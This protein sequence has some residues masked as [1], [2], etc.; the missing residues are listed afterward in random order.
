[1]TV[2]QV[3]K[4]PQYLIVGAGIVGCSLAY[5]FSKHSLDVTVIEAG[6]LGKQGASAVPMALLNPN[7]GR[8]ARAS[9]LD[10]NGLAAMQ[11]LA[12]E[13]EIEGLEHGLQFPGVLRIA[14]NEK[15]RKKFAKLDGVQ[16]L[17]AI[18]EPYHA[19]FGG[20]LVE[21]GGWLEPQKF[22][23]ALRFGAKQRGVKFIEHTRVEGRWKKEDGRI[24]V[25]TSAD[26][27]CA[28]KVFLCVGAT[29]NAGFD[30]PELERIE[31]DVIALNADL[32]MPYPI[33][34]A[35]YGM[36][37]G[38]QVFMGGNHRAENETDPNAIHR[39]KKSSSWFIKA[40]A[41]TPVASAWSG[42]RAKREDNQPLITELEKDVWFVGALGGRGFLCSYYLAKELCQRLGH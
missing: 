27:F 28:D 20:I 39:L 12:E 38:K 5:A 35:I 18:P 9:D 13:L 24:S 1:M 21:Q 32:A 40:L 26:V 29:H 4:R 41:D 34:G 14:H 19:P 25:R 30:L 6:E 16:H 33:A 10:K 8:T 2:P 3:G 17:N 11:S 15:Q 42:V 36:Q 23:K 7:R 31:G 37:K 22:L